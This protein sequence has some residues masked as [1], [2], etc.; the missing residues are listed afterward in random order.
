[1][2]YLSRDSGYRG[3][4]AIEQKG[5]DKILFA[6]EVFERVLFGGRTEVYVDRSDHA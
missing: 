5:S 6:K 1:M 3:Y 2:I 4:Y